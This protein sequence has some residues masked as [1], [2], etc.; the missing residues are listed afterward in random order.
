[1]ALTDP[2]G[3]LI[4]VSGVSR[5]SVSTTVA[6]PATT[7]Y[8]AEDVLSDSASAGTSWTFSNV[9]AEEGGSGTIV[10]AL[11]ICQTTQV[12][13]RP[14]LYLYNVVPTSNLND[15]A[16]NAAPSWTDRAGYIGKITFP[17]LSDKGGATETEVNPGS[18][19]LPKPFVCG[20]TLRDIYGILITEDAITA[21]SAGHSY[22]IN[23][24]IDQN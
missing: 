3:R 16:G 4:S 7:D 20:V 6:V 18:G 11:C 22:L 21:E 8:A 12:T 2:K 9:V 17:A 23:L 10:N 24:L 5:V 14:T 13:H 19:G 1:M 15:N